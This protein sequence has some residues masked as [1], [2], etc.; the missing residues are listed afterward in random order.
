VITLTQYFYDQYQKQIYVL[1]LVRLRRQWKN[2]VTFLSK[3][4]FTDDVTNYDV[5]NSRSNVLKNWYDSL[6]TYKIW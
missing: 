5:I 3:S 6:P 2:Y 4:N 1:N